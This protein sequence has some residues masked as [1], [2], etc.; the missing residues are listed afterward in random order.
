LVP[1]PGFSSSTPALCLIAQNAAADI[2][3]AI[4]DLSVEH[5]VVARHYHEAQTIALCHRDGRA[6]TED[7]RLQRWAMPGG[8]HPH[9]QVQCQLLSAQLR[10]LPQ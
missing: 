10:Q 7:L 9:L 6:T 2:C 5:P 8:C 3:E 4:A 1:L